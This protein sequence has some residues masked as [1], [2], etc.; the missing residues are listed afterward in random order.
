MCAVRCTT[1][2]RSWMTVYCLMVTARTSPIS[3]VLLSR[4]RLD[5]P[6]R[7]SSTPSSG[8]LCA[9]VPPE[10]VTS[11]VAREN[12]DRTVCSGFHASSEKVQDAT[13]AY[14]LGADSEEGRKGIGKYEMDSLDKSLRPIRRI[15]N[16]WVVAGERQHFERWFDTAKISC[17]G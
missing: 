7:P 11:T 12:C 8:P 3:R 1:S 17:D 9:Q 14:T 5:K 16:T 6:E 10:Q 15:A 4:L 13:R 2:P